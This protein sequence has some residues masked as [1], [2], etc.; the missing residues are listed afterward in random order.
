MEVDDLRS[1]HKDAEA[2]TPW[3]CNICSTVNY[4]LA[5]C[6]RCGW[7]PIA[8]CGDRL[9]LWAWNFDLDN[10]QHE[11]WIKRN[12]MKAEMPEQGRESGDE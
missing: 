9:D 10:L 6:I 7:Q 4:T 8:F 11:R 12:T 2:V 3:G 5:P 1:D